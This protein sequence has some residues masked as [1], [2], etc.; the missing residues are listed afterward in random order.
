[1]QSRSVASSRAEPVRWVR[2][3]VYSPQA[4]WGGMKRSGV[5]GQRLRNHRDKLTVCG[6]TDFAALIALSGTP[7][8]RD[9]R[10]HLLWHS[11]CLSL[12]ADPAPLCCVIR[13][14]KHNKKQ[15]ERAEVTMS[16][17]GRNKIGHGN[18]RPTPMGQSG[19]LPDYRS[20][21]Y[22]GQLL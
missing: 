5:R 22:V 7:L 19:T 17:R 20:D 4:E 15:S 3:D 9:V 10:V 16:R 21:L 2:I 18:L 8:A 1:M 6:R 11:Q 14:P 13:N 12:C